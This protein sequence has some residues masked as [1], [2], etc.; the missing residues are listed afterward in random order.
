MVGMVTQFL[1]DAVS[2]HKVTV[3][4]RFLALWYV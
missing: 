1:T 4:R 2:T 3:H